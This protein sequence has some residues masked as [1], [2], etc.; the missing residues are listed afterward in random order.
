MNTARILLA[1]STGMHTSFCS[2]TV[3]ED[4]IRISAY[5]THTSYGSDFVVSPEEA[6]EVWESKMAA[7]WEVDVVA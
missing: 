3:T 6:K 2:F 4:G 1:K 7:G 5:G